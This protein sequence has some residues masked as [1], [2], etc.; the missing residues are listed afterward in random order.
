MIAHFVPILHENPLNPSQPKVTTRAEYMY[1]PFAPGL[2]LGR[3]KLAV[4]R[5]NTYR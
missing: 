1:T 5:V 4:V 3:E 2:K